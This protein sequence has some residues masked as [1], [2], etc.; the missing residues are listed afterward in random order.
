MNRQARTALKE[1]SAG[2]ELF[3][4]KIYVV[5]DEACI[6]DLVQAYLRRAGFTVQGFPSGEAFL[7]EFRKNPP[8]LVVLDIMMPGMDGMAV[9]SCIRAT[10]SV[11]VVI[12]SA[13]GGEWDKVAALNLGG[14]D[15]LVKPFSPAELTARVKNLL[16]YAS[17]KPQDGTPALLT[18]E[19]IRLVPQLREVRVRGQL[20]NL[21]PMEYEFL[22]HLLEN[23]GTVV[24]RE[25][26][27]RRVWNVE[28]DVDSRMVDNMVLRI[29]KKIAAAQS[30]V[31]IRTVRGYGFRIDKDG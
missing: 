22:R 10:S 7:A 2:P 30:R 28:A 6:R 12:I 23:Q 17:G 13:K 27:L 26:L 20:V 3:P 8:D 1:W 16:R 18:Y 29:R 14:N 5:D 25:A 19:D 31:S 24:R 11:P 9:C 4:G 15:Y 21:T